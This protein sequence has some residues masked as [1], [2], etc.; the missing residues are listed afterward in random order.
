MDGEEGE[1]LALFVLALMCLPVLIG[2]CVCFVFPSG[3]RHISILKLAG[4]EAADMGGVLELYP[5]NGK[6]AKSLSKAK[7]TGVTP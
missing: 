4:T 1:R 3:L 2:L 5:I 7:V 6:L